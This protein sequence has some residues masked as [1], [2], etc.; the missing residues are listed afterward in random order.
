[1][2]LDLGEP[3]PVDSGLPHPNLLRGN[4]VTPVTDISRTVLE[5]IEPG[6]KA[7]DLFQSDPEREMVWR[8]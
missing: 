1:M 4:A 6:S 8:A 7:E 2:D 3:L 5:M